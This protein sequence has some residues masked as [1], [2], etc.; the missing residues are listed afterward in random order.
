MSITGLPDGLPGAAPM[1]VG[2]NFS[3]TVAGYQALIGIQAALLERSRSGRGQHLDIA[4][5]DCSVASL[6]NVAQAYLMSGRPPG[7]EGYGGGSGGPAEILHCQG[8]PVFVACGTDAQ[9]ARFAALL[10]RSDLVEDERFRTPV[11]RGRN[12]IA[13]ARIVLPLAETWG[14]DAMLA[15]LREADIPGG[16]V[17]DVAEA[18]EDPQV[19]WRGL[20]RR[21]DHP[22]AEDF[23]VVANPVRF[24]RTPSCYD[25]PPPRLGEHTEE[26]LRELLS[27]SVAEIAALRQAKAI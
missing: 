16:P 10:G 26:V 2:I 6:S 13:L 15:A 17:N 18:F 21:M 1:K 24:S 20:E 4:L 22:L 9:F 14:R 19:K 5:L 23:R 27:L 12:K 25:R 11:G 8:G 3:D 7:R